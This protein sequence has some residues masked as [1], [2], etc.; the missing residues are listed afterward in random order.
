MKP[1]NVRGELTETLQLDLIGPLGSLGDPKEVL[2]Q[3]P[4]KWYLT[5]FLVPTDAA[6]DQRVDAESA[7]TMDVMEE[8]GGSDDAANPDRPSARRSFMPSSIGLSLLAPKE[9]LKLKV[10]VNWGDYKLESDGLE[11]SAALRWRRTPRSESLEIDTPKGNAKT[12][13]IEVPNSPKLY[14]SVSVRSVP[15]DNLTSGIPEGTRSVSLFLVNRRVPAGEARMDEAFAFQTQLE[16]ASE[17]PFV[18]RPNLHSL[19][20]DEW[21]E[22]VADLQYRDSLEYSVGHSI[23]TRAISE[24][25]VC[26]LVK[27]CWLPSAEVERVAPAPIDGVELRMQTL[28]LLRDGEK[29][30][31]KLGPFAA[32]YR[33]WIAK[34]DSGLEDLPDSRKETVAHLI[35]N[36][37]VAADRIES[38]IQLLSLIHI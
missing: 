36:A 6:E 18:A 37:N 1:V 19:E 26:R 10:V 5:G 27:T 9:C 17:V 11:Q 12:T 13:E 21:D 34:Q 30:K 38:G 2:R 15:P 28:S 23:S 22:L 35:V 4:S 29:A 31:E 3:R 8:R 14:V 33:E 25:G 16:V 7:D 24:E 20:S 32:Q